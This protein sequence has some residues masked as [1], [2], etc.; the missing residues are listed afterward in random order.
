MAVR[1][2]NINI[3]LMDGEANGRIKASISNWTGVAYKIPRNKLSACKERGDMAQSSV[4]FL[5]GTKQTG[6]RDT[7][8]IGQAG[9]RKNGGGILSRLLEH[10]RNPEKDYW[11][12]AVVFTTSN[13]SFGPTELSYLENAF[14]NMAI[15]SGRFE[16]MNSNEPSAGNITEEKES[17]LQEYADFAEL[18]LGVLGYKVFAPLL[19][20]DTPPIRGTVNDIVSLETPPL[21]DSSLK[22]GEFVR[23]AM[24]N[25]AASGY[26]FSHEQIATMCSAE[27]SVDHFHTQKPFMKIVTDERI[28]T[29][30]HDA[31]VRFWSEVFSFGEDAVLISKEWYERQ[32]ELFILWYQKL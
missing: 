32:R 28:D 24:R 13:N 2:K 9:V 1:G 7:V 25:L 8:Y 14:C 19:M 20:V 21:P 27:W 17:E 15:K 26:S 5:F 30:G 16:V 31:R 23:T 12:E 3:F 22:I 18:I 29:R 10:D 11:T 4:Y 6:T